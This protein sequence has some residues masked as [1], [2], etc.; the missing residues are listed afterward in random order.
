MFPNSRRKKANAGVQF[1]DTCAEV[2]T[3]MQRAQRRYGR[4]RDQALAW[5]VLR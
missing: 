2:T 3:T 1:C 4:T 5:T